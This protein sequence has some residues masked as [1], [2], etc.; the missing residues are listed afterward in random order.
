MNTVMATFHK[1]E[2]NDQNSSM[3]KAVIIFPLSNNYK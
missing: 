1:T 2:I 3:K